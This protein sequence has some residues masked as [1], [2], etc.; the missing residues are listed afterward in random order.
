MS[1][2]VIDQIRAE[3]VTGV[4]RFEVRRRRGRAA[5]VSVLMVVVLGAS[6]LVWNAE[7]DGRSKLLVQPNGS[8]T[9]ATQPS[10]PNPHGSLEQLP[11][12]PGHGA[13]PPAVWTGHEFLFVGTIVD[14]GPLVSLAFDADTRAWRTIATPP[15]TIGEHAVTVWT[16]TELVV[17]CGLS[18]DGS[19]AAAYDPAA[20]HWRALPAPP[21]HGYATAVWT[22]TDV[23]VVAADGVASFDPAHAVWTTLPMPTEL[24]T[25]NKSVWTGTELIIWPAP[26]ARTVHGGERFDPET[27]TWSILPA[28]PERSWPAMPDISWDDGSLV[29]VGGLPAAGPT[30]ERLVDAR[31]DPANDTWKSLPDPLPEPRGCECNLGSQIT[32]WTGTDLLL[33]TDAL[34]SGWSSA[35][36]LMAYDP[37]RASWRLVGDTVQTALRPVVL[38]G[39]R[40]LLERGRTY[41]LSSAGWSPAGE[42]ATPPDS[43]GCP[44][45]QH[46]WEVSSRSTAESGDGLPASG[47]A[48]RIRAY[49]EL[50]DRGAAITTRYGA[51]SAGVGAE[52]GRAVK[53][54][55]AKIEILD[56][57]IAT[58]VVVLPAASECPASP[59][60]EDGI[61]LTFIVRPEG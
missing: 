60:F 18:L 5:G 25:F 58:I 32:L 57:P 14:Q 33:Y 22:G 37:G 24:A 38:A 56:E 45:T 19:G 52:N 41:Y 59:A 21:V 13:L 1:R 20:N 11:A 36:V 31:Y 46:A 47:Y 51:V 8:T 12:P 35:G 50:R 3:L 53:Q 40:V 27:R 4:E 34:A 44:G 61:P 42:R 39:D 15:A 26:G 28:P 49:E 16:G 30:S 10:A 6:A 9:T 48:T 29:L 7:H 23:I 55:G 43:V 17:C 54:V 2:S